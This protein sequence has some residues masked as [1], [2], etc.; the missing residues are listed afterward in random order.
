MDTACGIAEA[1]L[2]AAFVIAAA[3]A[4][5]RAVESC[6]QSATAGLAGNGGQC[7]LRA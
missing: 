5:L 3:G 6:E 2:A 1:E 7:V 4:E